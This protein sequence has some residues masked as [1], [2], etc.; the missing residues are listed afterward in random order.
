MLAFALVGLTVLEVV[1]LFDPG[2][3]PILRGALRAR[4][5]FRT[6]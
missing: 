2:M 1:E 3:S 4:S 6:T 5:L